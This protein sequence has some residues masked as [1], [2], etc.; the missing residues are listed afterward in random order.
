MMVAVLDTDDLKS[1]AGRLL[2]R[3]LPEEHRYRDVRVEGELGD[4]E[5]LLHGFGH[6]L[7]LIRGTSEQAYADAFAEPADNG[8]ETQ[9][10]LLPYLAELVGAEL[11]APDPKRRA[12]ELNNSV[13]WFKTKGTL[14]NVDAV[15]DVV[16][17]ME[18]VA[19][20]GWRLVLTTPC[21]SLPPFTAPAAMAGMGD[22]LGP[23]AR[24]LGTPDLSLSNRAVLD[25]DGTSPLFRLTTPVRDADGRVDAPSVV[26]WRPR[27]RRGVPCFPNGYDDV[28]ARTP[29][30]R[31]PQS[32]SL[33][34]HPNRT[35]IYVRPPYG[36][37]EPGLKRVTLAGAAD[38]ANPLDF[39]L[40][41]SSTQ[42]YGPAEVLA[43]LGQPLD[44]APDK[45]EVDGNLTIPNP[46][47]PLGLGLRVRFEGILFRGTLTVAAKAH[48][49]LRRCAAR[50]VVLGAPD[51]EPALDA[52]DCL[53]ESVTGTPGFAQ[54]VYCTVL[55]NTQVARLHASDCLFA[56]PLTHVECANDESCVRFSRIADIS[57]LAGC[58]FEKSPNNTTDPPIF[59]R[60]YFE[61]AGGCALRTA[62]FGEPGCG[63]LDLP[64]PRSIQH[65]AENGGEMGAGNHLY[66]GARVRALSLKLQDFLPFGQEIAVR[67]DPMLARG[68]VALQP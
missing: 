19:A 4:L 36:L 16:S 2:Y 25:P 17:G 58:C 31:D 66:L 5:A 45:I 63:V 49:T 48:L 18:T 57:T 32:W 13:S 1:K 50:S 59:A 28:S 35:L 55:G 37:F 22:P 39:K 46:N 41:V 52:K 30:L 9:T 26:Y 12:E 40:N 54:L 42:V 43:A 38:P 24:P 3:E 21:A 29:D 65:G 68:P 33:G 64:T 14:L 67:Y 62:A 7:D 53:F 44:P 51:A 6:Q 10:W 8:R 20:E 47:G 23:P 34:P 27:A 60:L 15:A 61:D 11:L 56:G